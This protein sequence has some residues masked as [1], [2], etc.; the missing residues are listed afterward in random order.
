MSSIP[1]SM[2]LIQLDLQMILRIP[3]KPHTEM[4]VT[5][6]KQTRV[7]TCTDTHIVTHSHPHTHLYINLTLPSEQRE[8]HI[9]PV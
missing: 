3:H 1:L 6:H 7:N 4:H 9:S 2:T 5:V 8:L